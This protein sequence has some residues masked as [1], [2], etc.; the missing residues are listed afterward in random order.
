M[1]I[2]EEY[3]KF[4]F[5]WIPSNVSDVH[6]D[7][8]DKIPGRLSIE[9]GG[10]IELELF[11]ELESFEALS[12]EF[13]IGDIL[14]RIVG[15]VEIIEE[16]KKFDFITLDNCSCYKSST[17]TGVQKF[18]FSVEKA[19][20]GVQYEENEKPQFNTF[21]FF[22][23]GLHQWIT[24]SGI[25]TNHSIEYKLPK[26]I[27]YKVNNH[28]SFSFYFKCN[29]DLSNR[30]VTEKIFCKIVSLEEQSIKAFIEIAR[31]INIFLYFAMDDLVCINN[32]TITSDRLKL[33][34]EDIQVPQYIQL[35]YRSRPFVKTTPKIV[36]P[37]FR[38]DLVK[39]DME[40]I[41]Q[42][43]IKLYDQTFPALELYLSTQTDEQK[44]L[45]NKF[46]TLIQS[47][48]AYYQKIFSCN[49]YPS[50]E[51]VLKATIKPLKQWIC[52]YNEEQ[53]VKNIVCTRHY[54]THYNPKKENK[55]LKGRE[56]F[57]ACLKL[58]VIFQ[59]TLLMRIGFSDSQIKTIITR[60]D[61]NRD[62]LKR[63]IQLLGNAD[64]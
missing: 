59:I 24:Y 33:R 12:T 34:F 15:T 10:R 49:E 4:G 61:C 36:W 17:S 38:F 55:A 7:K 58:E 46:L 50:T 35:F 23:E 13:K 26:E 28:F 20:V 1:R 45:E 6:L 18:V 41:L 43:W 51:D 25:K 11:I 3:R 29:R 14:P 54:F 30:Q 57:D 27:D 60:N 19:F 37:L 64:S 53:L 44:F 40:R 21:C 63:K 5:F 42:N 56:L 62:K 22:M 48:E 52:I 32:V 47:L 39:N 2:K 8:K 9:N 31:K 16:V